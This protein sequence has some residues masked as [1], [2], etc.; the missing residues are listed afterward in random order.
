MKRY[1]KELKQKV[2]VALFE[3]DNSGDAA[4]GITKIAR[5]NGINANVSLPVCT[6]PV[7]DPIL[8]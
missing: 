4:P 5:D 3:P 6:A 1:P 7:N 2:V 8:M